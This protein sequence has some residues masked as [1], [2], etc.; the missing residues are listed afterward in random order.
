MNAKSIGAVIDGERKEIACVDLIKT[1]SI[2]EDERAH[3]EAIEYRLPLSDGIPIHR[4]ARITLKAPA[5][6]GADLKI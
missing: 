6:A 5:K 2:Y 3:I 1:T 4:S